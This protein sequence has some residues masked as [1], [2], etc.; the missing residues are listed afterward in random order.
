MKSHLTSR[1]LLAACVVLLFAGQALA[2]S[3]QSSGQDD[4]LVRLVTWMSGSFSSEEQAANDSDFFDIRLHVVRIWPELSSGVWLY[5]EQASA[6]SLDKPYRQRVYF[7]HRLSEELFESKVF[8]LNDPLRFAGEWR[9]PEPLKNLSPDS[10]II[11]E[12]CSI[13]LRMRGTE[14]FVGNTVGKECSSD[15]R[16]ASYAVSEVAITESEMVSWDRGFDSEG[17]QVWGAT[18]GGYIFRK[19]QQK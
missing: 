10:L 12:G 15:L 11:R 5:V 17:G 4:D 8:S 3:P 9:N 18:K 13:V 6:S 7:V 2:Q 19:L 1:C 14:A 16:G